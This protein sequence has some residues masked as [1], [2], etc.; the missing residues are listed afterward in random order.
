MSI[1]LPEAYIISNQMDKILKEKTI[2]SVLISG[3]CASLIR[4]GFIRINPENL[5]EH[6]ILGV[7]S[8]G[9]WIFVQL[10]HGL[11]L[12]LALE[13]GGK[14]LFHNNHEAAPQKLHIRLD[15]DDGAKL[16]VWIV[17]WG[18][19]KVVQED[20]LEA[21]R[22][23]GKLGLS[24]IDEKE[25]TQNAFENILSCRKDT[26]KSVLLD[27]WTIAGIGNGYAQDILFKAK[28]HPKRKVTELSDIEK[29]TIYQAIKETMHDSIRMGGSECEVDLFGCPGSYKKVFGE[30]KKALTCPVC[31]ARIEKLVLGSSTYFCPAC[32][33]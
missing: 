11:Y 24:P 26:I 7:I 22:Y 29:I 16:S 12:L 8:K 18:F 17:G 15:F 9:K 14:I 19:A 30:R 5:Q 13:T 1:E 4:Q 20:A 2:T 23:P 21:D 10:S 25:F 3:E 6:K 28:I 33:K 31:G 27:Q 32:Q